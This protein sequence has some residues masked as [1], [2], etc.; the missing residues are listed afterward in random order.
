[1]DVVY[2]SFVHLLDPNGERVTQSDHQPGGVHYPTTIWRRGERLRDDHVLQLPE[3]APNGAYSLVAGLYALSAE[4]T[5]QP[6]GEPVVIGELN[7]NAGAPVEAASR[8]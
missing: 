2:H 5:V 6:L 8:R 4:G 1:M 7:L 3:D